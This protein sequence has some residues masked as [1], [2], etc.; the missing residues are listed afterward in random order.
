[1]DPVDTVFQGLISGIITGVTLILTINQLI[2]SQ[3][4]GPL[5]QQ[6]D[7][8]EGTLRFRQDIEGTTD[9]AVASSHPSEFLQA[10]VEAARRKA[11][12]LEED[13]QIQS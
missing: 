12:A 5:G 13:L 4:L 1:L 11:L 8:L 7:R 2:I 9:L 3:Q 6:R 10:L